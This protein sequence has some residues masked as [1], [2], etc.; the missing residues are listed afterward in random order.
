MSMGYRCF[1]WKRTPFINCHSQLTPTHPPLTH[2]LRLFSPFT[3]ENSEHK[4]FYCFSIPC[5]LAMRLFIRL[6]WQIHGFVVWNL[7]HCSFFDGEL[8]LN[9]DNKQKY[10]TD[11]YSRWSQLHSKAF[12]CPLWLAAFP[13]HTRQIWSSVCGV[14]GWRLLG[15]HVPGWCERPPCSS[16]QRHRGLLVLYKGK[17]PHRTQRFVDRSFGKSASCKTVRCG[18]RMS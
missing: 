5:I 12:R 14:C 16:F 3:Q 17:A 15:K 7:L 18:F 10:I 1:S 13:C 6:S 9:W 4:R 2:S 11:L 8:K